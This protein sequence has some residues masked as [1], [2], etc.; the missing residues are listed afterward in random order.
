MVRAHFPPRGLQALPPFLS[1]GDEILVGP[2]P[3]GYGFHA[4]VE[5]DNPSCLEGSPWSLAAYVWLHIPAVAEETGA[6]GVHHQGVGKMGFELTL[7][8]RP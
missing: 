5:M 2:E 6:Q 3:C 7:N 1:R 4:E 8:G